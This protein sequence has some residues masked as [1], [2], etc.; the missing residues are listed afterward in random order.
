[1]VIKT[2]NIDITTTEKYFEY[3]KLVVGALVDSYKDSA[4][5]EQSLLDIV[6]SH[7]PVKV[8][9]HNWFDVKTKSALHSLTLVDLRFILS[10]NNK[11]IS[12]KKQVLMDRIWDIHHKQPIAHNAS[13]KRNSVNIYV[14]DSDDE[15]ESL[16]SNMKNAGEIFIKNR[17]VIQTGEK[18][19]KRKY[20]A[21][22]N[23]VFKEYKDRY[24]FLGSIEHSKLVLKDVPLEITRMV[25]RH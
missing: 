15:Y 18:R 16:Y 17:R 8:T 19:F 12:G 3:A 9:K 10:V 21:D 22:K 25:H 4:I 5:C 2:I 7:T 23:W 24:E 6:A 13:S 14:D 20:I 1:M 11:P